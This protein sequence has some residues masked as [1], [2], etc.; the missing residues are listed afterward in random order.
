MYFRA[1]ETT[2]DGTAGASAFSTAE[3][4]IHCAHNHR[5]VHI[6]SLNAHATFAF[7]ATNR[8]IEDLAQMVFGRGNLGRGELW[9]RRYRWLWGHL[10]MITTDRDVRDCRSCGRRY[11]DCQQQPQR[12]RHPA[13]TTRL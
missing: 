7:L 4:T 10:S 12:G 8:Q 2:S 3:T 11:T 9:A 6:P 5:G 13:S 1:A